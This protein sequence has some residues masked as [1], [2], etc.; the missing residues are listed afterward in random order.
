M[1]TSNNYNQSLLSHMK[2]VINLTILFGWQ[3]FGGAVRDL[4]RNVTPNDLDFQLTEK[5]SSMVQKIKE[6]KLHLAGTFQVEKVEVPSSEHYTGKHIRFLLT[7]KLNNSISFTIDLISTRQP[8]LDFL[9]NGF[10][11]DT[12]GI[13]HF[14]GE[15][16][17]ADFLEY[18]E[19]I[20]N[21]K[22]TLTE[23]ASD[24]MTRNKSSCFQNRPKLLYRCCKFLNAGWKLEKKDMDLFKKH[25]LVELEKCVLCDKCEVNIADDYAICIEDNHYHTECYKH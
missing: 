23:Y 10:I 25:G 15:I 7:S 4:I 17:P 12:K 19:N 14:D 13:R 21:S 1:E 20:R 22:L 16:S 8:K 6:L 24:V 9:E 5:R 18:M 11:Q 3:L 2:I